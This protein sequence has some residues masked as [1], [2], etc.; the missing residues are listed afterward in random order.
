MRWSLAAPG[1]GRADIAH[2]RGKKTAMPEDENVYGFVAHEKKYEVHIY[3]PSRRNRQS[4][5]EVFEDGETLGR[6]LPTHENELVCAQ[7]VAKEHGA[8]NNRFPWRS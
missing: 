2:T 3:F 8:G 4:S 6:R 1:D 7:R 5:Y